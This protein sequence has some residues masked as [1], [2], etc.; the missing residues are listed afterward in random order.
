M[1]SCKS[2]L[3]SQ[4]NRPFHFPSKSLIRKKILQC[5]SHM[6]AIEAVAL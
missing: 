3:K 6:L 4:I 2:Y 1:H 5:V